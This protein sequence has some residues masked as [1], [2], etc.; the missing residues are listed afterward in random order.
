MH[1]DKGIDEA[2]ACPAK[3]YEDPQFMAQRFLAE[4]DFLGLEVTPEENEDGSNG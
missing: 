2:H 4:D 3:Q 1:F